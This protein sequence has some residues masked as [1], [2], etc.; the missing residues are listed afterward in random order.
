MCSQSAPSAIMR[1]H[2]CV[3]LDKSEARTEGEMIA[4]AI[5]GGGG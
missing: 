2:S 5:V 1:L 3:R 4:F